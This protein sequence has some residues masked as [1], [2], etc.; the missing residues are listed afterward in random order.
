[1]LTLDIS[2]INSTIYKNCI[3]NLLLSFVFFFFIIPLGYFLFYLFFLF[4][5]IFLSVCFVWMSIIMLTCLSSINVHIDSIKVQM[6]VYVYIVQ[7][8]GCIGRWVRCR[9]SR[10]NIVECFLGIYMHHIHLRQSRVFVRIENKWKHSKNPRV[11]NT[12]LWVPFSPLAPFLIYESIS[13]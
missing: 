1:M 13:I 3:F 7:R 11:I 9:E 8:D 2:Y 5:F 12:C 4:Y 10:V 6:P